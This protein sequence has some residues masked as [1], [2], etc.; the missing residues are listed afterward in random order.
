MQIFQSLRSYMHIFGVD[1]NQKSMFNYR[2][3]SVLLVASQFLVSAAMFFIFEAETFREYTESFNVL[4]IASINTFMAIVIILKA[5]QFHKLIEM[6][7]QT[8]EDRK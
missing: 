3:V 5:T 2:N 6:F 8:I 1:P 4:S 7:E